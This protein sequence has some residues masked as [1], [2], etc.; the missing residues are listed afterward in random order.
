MSPRVRKMSPLE[1]VE[2]ADVEAAMEGE[3]TELKRYAQR[4][5][6]TDGDG[7]GVEFVPKG[8]SMGDGQVLVTTAAVV[9]GEDME[10]RVTGHA[11]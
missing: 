9:T 6:G 7:D 10:K 3:H 2:A 11:L 4:P 1:E 8:M 5:A